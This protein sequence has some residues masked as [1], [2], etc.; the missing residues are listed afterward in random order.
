L[1]AD[2]VGKD[3]QQV[4]TMLLEIQIS[5][6]RSIEEGQS[7]PL[8][9]FNEG[10]VQAYVIDRKLVKQLRPLQQFSEVEAGIQ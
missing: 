4:Q 2:F 3:P 8:G 7:A 10:A 6:L 1:G 5:F 9:V